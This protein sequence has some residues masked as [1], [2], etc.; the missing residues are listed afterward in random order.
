MTLGETAC[1]CITVEN[2]TAALVWKSWA[3]EVQLGTYPAALHPVTSIL[4]RFEFTGR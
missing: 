4:S 1:V 3:T 2:R